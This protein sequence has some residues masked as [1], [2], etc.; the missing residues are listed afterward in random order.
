MNKTTLRSMGLGFLA[1][2]IL[3]GAFATFV[4]GKL[5]VQ[6]VKISSVLGSANDKELASYKD[7]TSSLLAEKSNLESTKNTLNESINSLKEA[8]SKQSSELASIKKSSS[9]ASA[10]ASSQSNESVTSEN[11]SSDESVATENTDSTTVADSTQPA[12][13]SEPAQPA[14]P[15]V[16]GTFVVN[17]GDNSSVIAQRLYDEGYIA[18]I[19]EFEAVVDEWNLSRILQAGTYQF[20]SNMGVHAILEQLTH[21]RYYYYYYYY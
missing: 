13:T 12:E 7:A 6:G 20:D 4:Q 2:A 18:S 1:S 15:A 5:P 10:S 14:P 17:S 19:E 9:E 21:G 8:T 3:T 16:S 11:A